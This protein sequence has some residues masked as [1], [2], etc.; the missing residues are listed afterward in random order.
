MYVILQYLNCEMISLNFPSVLFFPWLPCFSTATILSGMLHISSISMIIFR[1]PSTNRGAGKAGS[2]TAA[3]NGLCGT[4]IAGG[5]AALV[6][7]TTAGV[8]GLL[9]VGCAGTSRQSAFCAPFTIICLSS[10]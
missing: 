1:G 7:G 8:V 6:G 9:L 2:S 3:N 10:F 4:T 5:D